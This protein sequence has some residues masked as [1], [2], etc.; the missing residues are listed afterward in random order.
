[1]EFTGRIHGG[2]HIGR[3]RSVCFNGMS[4]IG[5]QDRTPPVVDSEPE[6]VIGFM[7]LDWF[8]NWD[9]GYF[10]YEQHDRGLRY[11]LPSIIQLLYL[12]G[13]LSV[14][15]LGQTVNTAGHRFTLI[16]WSC[17]TTTVCSLNPEHGSITLSASQHHGQQ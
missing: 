16:S 13:P 12:C 5:H 15:T 4:H 3:V 10:E 6:P 8:G 9:A 17:T 11:T 7:G 1:M 2:V 14:K